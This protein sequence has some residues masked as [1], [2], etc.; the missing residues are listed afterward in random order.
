MNNN[1]NL[2]TFSTARF[3]PALQIIVLL[4]VLLCLLSACGSAEGEKQK[5]LIATAANMQFAMNQMAQSFTEQT[6][7][8]CEVILSSSGKLSAQIMAGAP[9]HIFVSADELYPNSLFEKGLAMEAPKVYAYG[10]LVLW[11]Q[12]EGELKEWYTFTPERL[13]IANPETAPY[14]KA[15]LEALSALSIYDQWQNQ[16][17]YGESIAQVNQF[18]NSGAVRFGLTA[19]SVVLAPKLKPKG[20]WAAIA[21]SLY[22]PIAQAAVILKNDEARYDKARKFYD[23]LFSEPAK[24]ILHKFGYTAAE[25]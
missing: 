12:R 3:N 19:K 6:G 9:Y 21:D 2:K 4:S 7:I 16:L 15:A 13:A 10:H 24:E 8:E 1:K 14:G 5:L 25:E 18:V 11:S 20:Q 22:S 17:V 23:Y